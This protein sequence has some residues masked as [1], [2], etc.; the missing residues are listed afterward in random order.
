M[1]GIKAVLFDLDETLIDAPAGLSA[2]HE[3]VAKK[4]VNHLRKYGMRVDE[5][6]IRSKLD[7]FDD[8]MNLETKYNR[9][10]WWP[11]L[12]RELGLKQ[13]A[14][15]RKVE[16]LTE[17]YWDAYANMSRPY[18]DAE[19]TLNYLKGKGYKLG[20]I[21]D[22]DGKPGIKSK[23]LKRLNFVGLFDVVVVGGE[24]T[25][26]VKPSPEPFLLAASKLGLRA[27]E[28]AVVGDKPFTDIRGARAANMRAVWL[29][30][31]DWGIEEPAEFVVKS[32]AELKKIF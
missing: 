23:R 5:A 26:K 29:R 14:P 30:R 32:L 13:G 8:R 10:E 24:D 6:A 25:P 22:T 7:E 28:C 20:L 11:V 19:P 4:I 16:E 15:R 9:D 1:R 27:E 21:T 17:A 31:R 3:A 2:A 18:P 12:L